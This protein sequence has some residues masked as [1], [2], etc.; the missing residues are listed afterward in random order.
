MICCIYQFSH[1]KDLN[2]INRDLIDNR[3]FNQD[4]GGLSTDVA[5]MKNRNVDGN[6]KA[7]GFIIG[8]SI[9]LEAIREEIHSKRG[10]ELDSRRDVVEI[11]TGKM[12]EII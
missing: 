10:F 2:I 9:L 3:I 5:I 1:D 7:Q 6:D 8:V 12:I 11:I 4:I